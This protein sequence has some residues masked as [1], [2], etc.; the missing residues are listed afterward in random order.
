MVGAESV[1]IYELLRILTNAAPVQTVPGA[2]RAVILRSIDAMER[3][4]LF[5]ERERMAVAAA[6]Q[7]TV[8]L[9]ER[10]ELD[11]VQRANVRQVRGR[12]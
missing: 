9:R 11:R 1:S 6:N 7:E 2:D 4:D 8:E 5:G 3:Y 10:E 12:L